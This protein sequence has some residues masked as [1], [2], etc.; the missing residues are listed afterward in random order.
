MRVEGLSLKPNCEGHKDNG[1]GDGADGR[2]GIVINHFFT[3]N[4]HYLQHLSI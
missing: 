4:K 1:E 3:L 2:V